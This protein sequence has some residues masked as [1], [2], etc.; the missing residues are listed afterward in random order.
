MLE[1]ALAENTE[2]AH[3]S[4]SSSSSSSNH[5]E[6][7]QSI[8]DDIQEAAAT[9]LRN[10]S[11]METAATINT[12][13][14]GIPTSNVSASSLLIGFD[15]IPSPIHCSAPCT[16]DGSSGSG[17]PILPGFGN[18]ENAVSD[19]N[20]VADEQQHPPQHQYASQQYT[21]S[22]NTGVQPL[23]SPSSLSATTA[24]K[25]NGSIAVTESDS[26]QQPPPRPP[27]GKTLE[28][29]NLEEEYGDDLN[30]KYASTNDTMSSSTTVRRMKC[31]G[32]TKT[33]RPHRIVRGKAL[34]N[35]QVE[36]GGDDDRDDDYDEVQNHTKYVG[37]RDCETDHHR[38]NHHPLP[39][40]PPPEAAG[41]LAA[42]TDNGEALVHR[43][44]T[45]DC[46]IFSHRGTAN[47][48]HPGT[49]CICYCAV[50]WEV[51]FLTHIVVI[52]IRFWNIN[53]VTCHHFCLFVFIRLGN[54]KFR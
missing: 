20:D 47:T 48:K 37:E 38:L 15:S 26:S 10:T 44:S 36:T 33:R 16:V 5:D 41:P 43:R 42:Q 22:L 4:S 12:S 49:L 24:G 39:P 53:I 3:N 2:N 29:I 8:L 50:F 54:Q 11:R 23:S 45:K 30:D 17:L 1:N 14:E 19:E 27:R 21:C 7:H 9:I 32:T 31:N 52:L 35:I 46:D 13:S 6:H 25:E 18:D 34:L 28:Q 51:S 40:P